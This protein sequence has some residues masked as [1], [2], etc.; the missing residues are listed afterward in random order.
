MLCNDAKGSGHTPPRWPRDG[1]P[2]WLT[3]PIRRPMILVIPSEAEEPALS[4]AE[5][6][7]SRGL[8]SARRVSIRRCGDPGEFRGGRVLVVGPGRGAGLG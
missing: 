8:R 4:E 5:G 7:I 6:G 3:C 2:I 1:G